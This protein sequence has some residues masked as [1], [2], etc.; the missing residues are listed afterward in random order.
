MNKIVLDASA[1]LAMLND[2]P[3]A[4]KITAE[5]LSRATVSAVNLAEVHT[6]LVREGGDPDE[7]WTIG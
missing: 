1:I 6:M 5:L 7:S 2:E 4:E 3:G